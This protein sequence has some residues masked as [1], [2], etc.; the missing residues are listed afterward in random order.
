MVGVVSA[1]FSSRARVCDGSGGG[2]EMRSSIAPIVFCWSAIHSP[3]RAERGADLVDPLRQV[4]GIGREHRLLADQLDL[5]LDARQLGVEEGELLVGLA[6]A[7][8]ALLEELGLA[9]AGCGAG[10]R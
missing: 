7:R 9:F 2:S 10:R 1:Q 5:L 6:A 3:V 4:L 8:D